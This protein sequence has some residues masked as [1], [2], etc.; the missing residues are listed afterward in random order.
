MKRV[1]LLTIFQVPNYG[2]VLQTYATQRVL[3]KMGCQCDVINYRYPNHWH[4]AQGL[5]KRSLKAKMAGWLG[6]KPA[7]RKA[8]KLKKFIKE[9]LHL[10]REYA[11]FADLRREDWLK[12]YDLVA[13][14]SDQVWNTRFN[15]G[16][17][18]FVLSFL[19]DEM[20]RISIA[21]SFASSK[22]EDQ[23]RPHFYRNLSKFD[24]LSVREENGRKII[25]ELFSAKKEAEVL[26]DPTLLLGKEE[27]L[28]LVPREMAHPNKGRRYILL[29]GLYY[30][31]DPR[32][33]IFQLVKYYKEKLDCDVIVLDG[34]PRSCDKCSFEYINAMDSSVEDYLNLFKHA[35]LVITSSFHGTAFA[36]NFERPFISIISEG[37]DDRMMSLLAMVGGVTKGIK[38]SDSFSSI[39]CDSTL[40]SMVESE[41]L[42]SLRLESL[43]WLCEVLRGK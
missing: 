42:V 37:G 40:V 31:F 22:I 34:E 41:K 27:W 25:S 14:G 7:H 3:E 30:S 28:E 1:A 5:P 39:A 35:D 11:D 6:V 29:Y 8:N 4:Y 20:R 21:S 12:K 13:V 10:T 15:K 26:L 24:A 17:A 36:L 32:P 18:A 2:S 38:V 43:S 9:K 23:Y 19:P 33:Y 16:D